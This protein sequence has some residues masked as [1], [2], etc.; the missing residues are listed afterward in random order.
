MPSAAEPA[1]SRPSP[2]GKSRCLF[3]TLPPLVLSSSVFLLLF[4]PALRQ[5]QIGSGLRCWIPTAY[6]RMCCQLTFPLFLQI[7]THLCLP[8]REGGLVQSETA[9]DGLALRPGAEGLPGGRRLRQVGAAAQRQELHDPRPAS[10]GRVLQ[11]RKSK[12]TE[13]WIS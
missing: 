2:S 1:N 9:R 12:L 6:R 5:T 13:T 7:G 4:A 8:R 10:P 11:A 3:R